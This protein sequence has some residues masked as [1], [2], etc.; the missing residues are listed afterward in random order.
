[1]GHLER[2]EGAPDKLTEDQ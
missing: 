2:Y 1:V